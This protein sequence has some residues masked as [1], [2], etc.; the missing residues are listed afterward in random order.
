M[1]IVFSKSRDELTLMILM[2]VESFFKEFIGDEADVWESILAEHDLD[3]DAV[4]RCKEVMKVVFDDDFI[5][6]IMDAHADVFRLCK[7][8]VE[9]EV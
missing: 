3:V 2:F 4:V 8:G 1:P 6:D 5:R 7:R 9:V